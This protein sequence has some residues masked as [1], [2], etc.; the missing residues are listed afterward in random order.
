MRTAHV[1]LAAIPGGGRGRGSEAQNQP[2]AYSAFTNMV[3]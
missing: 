2:H 3:V 1:I